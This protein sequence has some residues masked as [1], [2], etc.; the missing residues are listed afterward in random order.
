[1]K[2]VQECKNIRAGAMIVIF[3]YREDEKQERNK[4]K[5]SASESAAFQVLQQPTVADILGR[6]KEGLWQTQLSLNHHRVMD[7]AE[8]GLVT[9]RWEAEGKRG[10]EGM[11]DAVSCICSVGGLVCWG[12]ARKGEQIWQHHLFGAGK[13]QSS[14]DLSRMHWGLWEFKKERDRRW[15]KWEK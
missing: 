3:N 14:M 10:M 1:M 4:C 6:L 9:R 7:A 12:G 5:T 15:K 11:Q 2:H 13:L 8:E